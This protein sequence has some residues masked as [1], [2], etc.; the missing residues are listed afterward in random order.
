MTK[1][2]DG[3]VLTIANMNQVSNLNRTERNLALLVNLDSATARK[4]NTDDRIDRLNTATV[5]IELIVHAYMV[6]GQRKK[7]SFSECVPAANVPQ[8]SQD[9]QN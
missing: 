4:A 1:A 3:L 2:V 9:T 7:C 6:F 8:S 5:I